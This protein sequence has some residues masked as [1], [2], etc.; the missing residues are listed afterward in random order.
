MRSFILLF[1]VFFFLQ[2]DSLLGERIY[3][4]EGFVI[5]TNGGIVDWATGKVTVSGK[6]KVQKFV[7][8]RSD[9]SYDSEKV[10]QPHSLSEARLAARREAE[11]NAIMNAYR[12][13]YSIRVN[14]E[15]T[16]EDYLKFPGVETKI[17]S[18][19][20]EKGKLVGAVLEDDLWTVTLEYNLFGP[21]GFVALND[22]EDPSDDFI[23]FH[24]ESFPFYF[25]QTNKISWE[26]LVISAPYLKVTPALAP[27]IYAENGNLLYD[28]SFLRASDAIES[29]IAVYSTSP[30]NVI[31]TV[32]YRYYHCFAVNT[33]TF[34]GTDIV[35]SD[36]DA[37]KIF[38]SPETIKNIR[39]CKVIILAAPP[40]F[41]KKR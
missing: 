7:K 16:V 35:I 5:R 17:N 23:R 26:G 9:V 33:T 31:K 40:S 30:F 32:N 27:K 4:I 10:F 22:E 39:K 8:N 41:N 3:K 19:I 29:G 36:S 34:E 14:N 2:F 20:K 37:Q 6:A 11:E 18:F 24:Q 12:V 28:C 13:F 1:L 15:T 38:S 25:K 21:N